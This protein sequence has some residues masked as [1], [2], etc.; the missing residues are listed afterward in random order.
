MIYGDIWWIYPASLP[1]HPSPWISASMSEQHQSRFFLKLSC[2]RHAPCSGMW[3]SQFLPH[4]MLLCN[5]KQ[6]FFLFCFAIFFFHRAIW[7]GLPKWLGTPWHSLLSEKHLIAMGFAALHE[8]HGVPGYFQT[9]GPFCS[10]S[11]NQTHLKNSALVGGKAALENFGFF[12]G[13]FFIYSKFNSM[14]MALGRLCSTKYPVLHYYSIFLIS[15]KK[16]WGFPVALL[17]SS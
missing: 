9:D 15:T 13:S 1:F 8:N 11:K 17:L 14:S 4:L 2:G 12:Q 10:Y 16:A 5:P 6:V 7:V 3:F